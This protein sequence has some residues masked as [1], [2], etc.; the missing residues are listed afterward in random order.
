[1][2]AAAFNRIYQD[3]VIDRL[4]Q[5]GFVK[6]ASSAYLIGDDTILALL[7]FEDKG[8]AL[9][10]ATNL[11]VCLR[12][13][14]LRELVELEVPTPFAADVNDYPVKERP[15]GLPKTATNWHYQPN[16]LGVDDT[17]CDRIE[18]GGLDATKAQALH[19]Q[20]LRVC[21]PPWQT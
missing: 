1:M 9:L 8:D 12:H 18:Y 4:L 21:V 7:R 20:S 16:N 19:L 14:F 6:H 10:Q 5:H 17:D 13:T 15:S 11:I 3:V 2:N